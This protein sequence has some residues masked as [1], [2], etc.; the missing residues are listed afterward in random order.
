MASNEP[1]PGGET[2]QMTGDGAPRLITQQGIPVAD[3]QNTLRAGQRG[4]A[5]L[6]GF[7]RL[8]EQSPADF[9]RQCG[10]L[11]LWSRQLTGG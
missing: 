1:A 7:V 6:E 2:Y 5:A 10:Q 8:D 3:D 11:R 9:L 4:P